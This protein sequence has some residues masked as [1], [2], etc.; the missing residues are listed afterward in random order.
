LANL[1]ANTLL[2]ILSDTE[3]RRELGGRH[4]LVE[5]A[6]DTALWRS[7][8]IAVLPRRYA[9]TDTD[10]AGH[11]IR[12]GDLLIISYL[13]ANTDPAVAPAPGPIQRSG[14][15]AH[16]AFGTGPH[17]CPARTPAHF[18][19][20]A[21]VEAA[22]RALP[23]L[24]LVADHAPARRADA[25]FAHA[26][27]A[28]PARS[29]PAPSPI[30]GEEPTW[31]TPAPAFDLDDLLAPSSTSPRPGPPTSPRPDRWFASRWRAWRSGR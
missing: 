21:A 2:L 11:P 20:T 3:M 10:L 27:A 30:P 4:A 14:A 25:P 15:R 8:P 19:A 12:A 1:S 23:G 7:P 6:V 5:E 29:T 18:I 13:G 16:L 28:L 31:I 26:L 22:L 9:A 24:R 17:Q